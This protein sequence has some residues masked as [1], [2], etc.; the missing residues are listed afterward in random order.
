MKKKSLVMFSFVLSFSLFFFKQLCLCE[1]VSEVSAS[2]VSSVAEREVFPPR[3]KKKKKHPPQKFL[4]E[5]SFSSETFPQHPST[6]CT[7]TGV[8]Q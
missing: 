5:N 4:P 3:T 7:A 6:L 2:A 1:V 8:R